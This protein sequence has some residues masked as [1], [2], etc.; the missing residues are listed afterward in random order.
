[1]SPRGEPRIV[2]LPDADAVA[3]AAA[4]RISTTLRA[5]VDFGGRADWATTGGSAS[6]GI[7]RRLAAAPLRDDLP[8]RDIHVWWGDDR[9]VRRNDPLSNVLAADRELLRDG[10]TMPES[11]V[12]PIPVDAAIDAGRNTAWAADAYE[13]ELHDADLPLRDGWPVLDLILIG[14][15]PDGHLLSVF[16]GSSALDEAAAW[17]LP[18]PAPTHV[19]P[20][21]ARVTLNPRL[22]DVAGHVLVVAW[23]ESKA[24]TMR[25][26]LGA[27]RDP[28]RLPAQLARRPGATW[29]L[30][31]AAAAELPAELRRA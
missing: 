15:G 17:V 9:F 3:D 30:D 18:I 7:Y 24:P 22:L 21:V 16:P 13:R 8:W 6:P 1:M 5:A 29:L 10:A 20:H 19:E 4:G 28:R 27:E 11:N 12:H 31:E 26:V 2:V 25:D 14:I 23:G